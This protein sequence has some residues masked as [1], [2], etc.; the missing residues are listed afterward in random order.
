MWNSRSI[1]N[2]IHTW[3]VRREAAP[4]EGGGRRPRRAPARET[5]D[6]RAA[7]P[8]VYSSESCNQHSFGNFAEARVRLNF[9]QA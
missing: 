3:S 7:A 6:S 8:A 4:R 5:E 9:Y 2:E 1:N